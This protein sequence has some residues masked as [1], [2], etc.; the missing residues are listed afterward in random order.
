MPQDTK[1][2]CFPR[3]LVEGLKHPADERALEALKKI[4]GLDSLTRKI[5]EWGLEGKI[6]RELLASCLRVSE[7]QCPSL[8]ELYL[9]CAKT[10]GVP[11]PPELFVECNPHPVSYIVGVTQAMI[12]VSTGLVDVLDEDELR[13][14]LGHEL[15]H[16]IYEHTLYQTMAHYISQ[17]LALVG[18]MTLG[19]GEIIGKGLEAALLSWSRVSDFSAD[20]AGLLACQDLDAAVRALVKLGAPSKKLWSEINIEELLRQAEELE[21]QQE[22]E[23]APEGKLA[24]LRSKVS[25]AIDKLRGLTIGRRTQPWPVLRIRE[26]VKW[27]RSPQYKAVLAAGLPLEA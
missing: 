21:A 12:V 19:I 6:R 9:D 25:G 2:L 22:Q 3:A 13:F 8:Y 16:F 23:E 10:L 18:R 7:K 15:G 11:E 26:L 5:I 14:V 20:R 24:K 17:I 4:R 27:A 1:R